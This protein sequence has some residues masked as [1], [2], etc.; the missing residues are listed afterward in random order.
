MIRRNYTCLHC[1]HQYWREDPLRK[2]EEVPTLDRR[3]KVQIITSESPAIVECTTTSCTHCE[4]F[5]RGMD[6]EE[7][8]R[9]YIFLLKS[10]LW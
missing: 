10:K 3:G 2:G 6:R 5:V 9:R 1:G 7:L 8:E 4:T